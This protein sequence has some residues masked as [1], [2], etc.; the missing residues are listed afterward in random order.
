MPSI[1]VIKCVRSA[2]AIRSAPNNLTS[3][4]KVE[5]QIKPGTPKNDFSIRLLRSLIH[6]N[7][8]ASAPASPEPAAAT[9]HSGPG[10]SVYA[11]PSLSQQNTSAQATPPRTNP[12]LQDP[13]E[14]PAAPSSSEPTRKKNNEYAQQRLRANQEALAERNRVRALVE[15]DKLERQRKAQ[16]QQQARRLA[17]AEGPQPASGTNAN[18][19]ADSAALHRAHDLDRR[20]T[21]AGCALQIRLFDGST[22][23]RKF[24]AE[25]T[26]R[27]A[28]RR[29][30]DGARGD[31]GTP[32]TFKLVLTPQP[33]RGLT[34]EDESRMVK[35]LGLVPSASL[36]LVRAKG[37]EEAY[38][39]S[40]SRGVVR[41]GPA[42]LFG[43]LAVL[44]AWLVGIVRVL[45]GIGRGEDRSEREMRRAEAESEP[46]PSQA[47]REPVAAAA[48]AG[49]DGSAGSSSS[50]SAASA[51]GKGKMR[52]RTLRDR[53]EDDEDDR[54]LYNGNTVRPLLFVCRLSLHRCRPSLPTPLTKPL[55]YSSTLNRTRKTTTPPPATADARPTYPSF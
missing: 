14:T 30:I 32:Y 16:Q 37:L 6:R 46:V 31:G 45:L 27:G 50:S 17:S 41:S 18:A 34:A 35:D 7:I 43:Y 1:L 53:R 29:W 44:W 8:P 10:S 2:T 19:H 38:R 54:Q 5:E 23:R 22:I 36:V 15:A 48:S 52:I 11:Q 39:A 47:Q 12:P 26:L 21:R 25:D 33:S 42:F 4:G 55:S 3:Q 13:T 24:S 20:T 40:G 51:Q 49:A 28:V 9:A